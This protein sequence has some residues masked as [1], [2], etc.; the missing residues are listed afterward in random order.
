MSLDQFTLAKLED[1]DGGKAFIAFQRHLTRAANDCL[2]RPNDGKPR[3]VTLKVA[4]VPA[5][6]PEGD[7]TEVKAQIFA[8][9]AVPK[10]RTKV[11]SF[12]LRKNGILVFNNDA[13]D[14]VSQ[15]T[16]LPE[17]DDE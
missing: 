11:Y 2:D 4:L 12:G 3:T 1:L 6:D 14:N 10:H 8:E 5:P 7:C 13:L 9:S 16:L 15:T 17:G